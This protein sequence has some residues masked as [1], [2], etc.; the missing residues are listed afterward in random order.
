MMLA[1]P[2]CF[3][4]TCAE[5]WSALGHVSPC[6]QPPRHGRSTPSTYYRRVPPYKLASDAEHLFISLRK[7]GLPES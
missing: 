4:A 7:A 3:A 5:D 2:R 6:R 1:K